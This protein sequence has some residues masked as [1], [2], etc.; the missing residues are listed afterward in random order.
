M[1]PGYLDR[2]GSGLVIRDPAPLTYEYTPEVLVGRGAAL[3]QL[4]SMFTGIDTVGISR[5]AVI[6]G[7]IGS[8]KSVMARRF[9]QDLRAHLAMR[10]ELLPVHVNC[11]SNTS[12][13][14]V[15]Q[16][17][18][19]AIDEGHP[20]RGFGSAELLQSMRRQLRREGHHLLVVLD[21]VD[22]LLQRDGHELLYQLLRID[23]ERDTSGTLSVILIS[24]TAVLDLLEPSVLSRLG[25]GRHVQLARYA[26]TE[27]AAIARQRADLA[28]V[29]GSCP[30]E[31]SDLIGRAAEEAGDARLAIEMLERAAQLAEA[32]GR[33]LVAPSDVQRVSMREPTALDGSIIDDLPQHAQLL[34]LAICRRLKRDP[35]VSSGEAEQLY[36]VVCEEYS[37]GPRSHTTIW[38]H[39]KVLEDRGIVHARVDT[40][41][42][43]RGRT[44]WFS[45]PSI[46]PAELGGRVEARL[47]RLHPEV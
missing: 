32:A 42:K 14:Q 28:L 2:I 41:A 5:Q 34:L 18:V 7:P 8:G 30:P 19:T 27:L 46:L 35:E 25:R 1:P 31:I 36:H 15:L 29:D 10:R 12:R 40:A 39:L 44:Q 9:G 47:R 26:A 23:E 43:G 16:R 3:K 4:A 20:D 11:R 38:K 37:E 17:L 33:S 22:H 6:T 13:A 21:E 24:Q 45:M